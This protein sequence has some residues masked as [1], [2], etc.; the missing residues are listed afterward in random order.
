MPVGVATHPP[1]YYR[2]RNSIPEHVA[3]HEDHGIL[4][5]I[6]CNVTGKFFET[7]KLESDHRNNNQRLKRRERTVVVADR[8]PSSF[9]MKFCELE[10]GIG[11]GIARTSYE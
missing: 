6:S 10:L 7:K 1:S 9:F 3:S 8:W 2:M 4:R 11:D 5:S